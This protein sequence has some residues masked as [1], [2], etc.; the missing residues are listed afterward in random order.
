MKDPFVYVIMPAH[1]AEKTIVKAGLCI[2][3]QSH[4]NTKLMIIDDGSTDGTYDE[5][6]KLIHYHDSI[7]YKPKYKTVI[8]SHHPNWGIVDSLNDGL[9]SAMREPYQADFIARMDADDLCSPCRIERQLNYMMENDL[10]LCGTWAHVTD[11]NG[12]PIED[13]HPSIPNGEEKQWLIK[14][15]Y[16]IHGS[17]MIRPSILEKVG[18]YSDERH[19]VEDFDLWLRIAN[20]GRIGILKEYLYTLVRQKDSVTAAHGNEVY[21]K[22]KELREMWSNRWSIPIPDHDLPN[23]STRTVS[24]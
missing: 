13:F 10:D 2:L 12:A 16:F 22:A 24:E 17:V 21:N 1:N 14:F 11:E 5:A 8:S 23:H 9:L 7:D 19:M 4:E 3:R 6:K 15:N 18:V 20:A